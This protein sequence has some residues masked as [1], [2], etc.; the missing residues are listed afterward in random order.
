MSVEMVNLTYDSFD[1]CAVSILNNLMCKE[2]FA[3]VTLVAENRQV[4]A[5]KFM[6]SYYSPFFESIFQ[7][8]PHQHPLIYLKGI[9][10]ENLQNVLKFVYRG[11]AMINQDKL[12]SFLETGQELEIKFLSVATA[13][14]EKEPHQEVTES[15]FV[16]TWSDEEER[17]DI[18]CETKREL[19]ESEE[20][21]LFEEDK[22]E[23]VENHP[24]LKISANDDGQ[25]ACDQCHVVSLSRGN[26]RRHKNTVHLK[27]TFPCDQCDSVLK[28]KDHLKQH[29]L[30]VHEGR[31][32][33]CDQCVFIAKYPQMLSSHMKKAHS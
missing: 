7:Q 11:E 9:S 14:R 24:K 30:S 16:Q 22:E 8:N 10:F 32:Y 17:Q 13:S 27:E 31:R 4:K 33:S 15:G 26:L 23:K 2:E 6:L 21:F 28:R 29:I 18:L 1:S 19:L 20:M 12:E 25:F 3:D 5:H